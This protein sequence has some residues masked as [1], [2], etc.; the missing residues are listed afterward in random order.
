[1]TSGEFVAQNVWVADLSGVPL[2]GST[3]SGLRVDGQRAIRAKYPNGDP[4]QSGRFLRGADQGMGGGDSVEGW[5]PLAAQTQWLPP[6]RKPNGTDI[7][8]TAADWPTVDWP[9]KEAGGSSWTGEGDW[10]ECV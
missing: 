3:L 6:R 1:V 2:R 4:E 5:V 7:V 10:G 8:V 9:M